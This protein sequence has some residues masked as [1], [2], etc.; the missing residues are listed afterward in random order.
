MRVVVAHNH[1][2]H[3]GGEDQ[4]FATEVR[5]LERRG[6]RVAFWT[7]SNESLRENGR[8]AGA[9]GT[10]WNR[11][12][13]A[14]LRGLIREQQ[15]RVVHFHNTFAAISPAATTQRSGKGCR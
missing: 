3:S 12:A 14:A 6:H 5:L 7:V 8:L 9:G 4:V 2:L 1:Y 13:S 15:P 10:I 11:A